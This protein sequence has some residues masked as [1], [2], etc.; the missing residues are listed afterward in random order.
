MCGRVS[1]NRRIDPGPGD[2][3]RLRPD[4]CRRTNHRPESVQ[5]LDEDRRSG[6]DEKG[7]VM[8]RRIKSH[9]FHDKLSDNFPVSLVYSS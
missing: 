6:S 5:S 4:T 7:E 9:R 8:F 1:E 3:H 2:F